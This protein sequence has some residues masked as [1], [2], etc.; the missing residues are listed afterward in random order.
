MRLHG[1]LIG[2]TETL[3]AEVLKLNGPADATTSRFFR[4]HPKLGH[5]ERGVIAEAVFAVLRRR[6]EFAHLAEG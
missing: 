3:L 6:M 1:F 5:G 2:Q 4:A